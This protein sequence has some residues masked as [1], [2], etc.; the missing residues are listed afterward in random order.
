MEFALSTRWNAYRHET[1][2]TL[3]DEIRSVGFTTIELGYDLRA[4]LVPGILKKV[5][6]AEIRVCSLHN[7]CPIP[8]GFL[9]G[10]PE[11]YSLSSLD[12]DERR[13]AV[14][15]TTKTIRF[16]A[17]TGA[18]AVVA[19]AGNVRMRRY[20][21]SLIDLIEAGKRHTPRY[22]K[23]LLKLQMMR[24]RKAPRHLD[25][26][27]RS[28]DELLPVLVETNIRLG[29][30]NLPDWESI[31]TEVEARSLIETV[32][33]PHIGVWHDTGHGR[34]RQNL[35]LINQYFWF[36]KLGG[37]LIGMH[38]HDVRPPADDHAAP[39]SGQIDFTPFAAIARNCPIRVFECLPGT[40]VDAV[41]E[42]LSFI[43]RAWEPAP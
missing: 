12:P 37:S 10:H 4:D 30:E 20:S 25:A 22:E 24:E 32:D 1:G 7:Y 17:E 33:N 27:R 29:F 2:E 40:P 8:I 19:H 16:A 21:R 35:G 6:G 42:G 15:Y 18:D 31:P 41:R 11:L 9:H 39:G 23:R 13:A 14:L 5:E 38:I 26:W 36:E 43:R 34:I 3:V 28:V